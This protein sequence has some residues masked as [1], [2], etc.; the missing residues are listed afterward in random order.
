MRKVLKVLFVI[1]AVA[2]VAVGS[3]IIWWTVRGLPSVPFW[4]AAIVSVLLSFVLGAA[5][6]MLAGRLYARWFGVTR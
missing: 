5:V 3:Q 4:P 1:V 6:G 2:A